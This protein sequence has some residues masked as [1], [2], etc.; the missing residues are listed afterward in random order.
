MKYK[1]KRL[2]TRAFLI[3]TAINVIAYVFAHIAYLYARV[4]SLFVLYFIFLSFYL[5][6][7]RIPLF[8]QIF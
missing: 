5:A 8:I 7:G 4:V 1:T 2:T 3:Y 6:V